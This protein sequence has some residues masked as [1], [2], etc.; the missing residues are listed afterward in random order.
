M[1]I[2]EADQQ[3]RADP[4][5]TL[6]VLRRLGVSVVRVYIAWEALAPD[7]SS[8]TSPAGFDAASPA[9]YPAASWVSYDATVRDAR[10]RG[11]HLLLDVGGP[12][13]QWATG[14]GAPHGGV[15][16][17]WK[18]SAAGFGQFVHA[19]ATRYSGHY[20][21]AGGSSPLP[22]I[23]F[24][25]IWNEPNLGIDLAPEAIENSAVETS[26]AMYRGLLDAGW[27]ALHQTGHSG[28]TILI[29]ELAPYGDTFGHNVP[30][31]FG[32]M[33]PLRFVRALYCVDSS[34]HPLAGP[35]AAARGCPTTT[36]ASKRFTSDHPALFQAGGYAV[37]P[38]PSGQVAPNVVIPD[39]PDFA[40]LAAL[41]KLEQLLDS[42]TSTYG[43]S[44]RFP[45]Y[46][47]EYGYFTDPPLSGTAPPALAAA[48]L[49]WAEYISWRNPR[50]RSWDQ[51]LL[52]DPPSPGPSKFVTG[53][54]FANGVQK[55][56]YAAY[57]MPI[58]LPATRASSGHELEVWGCVRPA[59]YARLDTGAPQRVQIQL[60]PRAG[61][62]FKTVRT[63]TI[64]D[65]NGYFET[66]VRFASSG[67]VRLAWSYP[68]GPTIYSRP[69]PITVS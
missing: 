34:L 35:A 1:S 17:V 29:G 27:S 20:I 14:A 52:I 46:S 63:V 26:P 15:V 54:E 9:A 37:H 21:P 56:S 13:P 66:H 39:E 38:Y 10:A 47:T 32:Y 59:R 40:N 4:S 49:N 22:R 18:P 53:L 30:G 36:A 41:P 51:F 67:T 65:P 57:R 58:Y 19:V 68:R 6:D 12:A 28:D 7:A 42:V 25:S 2:F 5:A 8:S 43:A 48:Y 3:L 55:P 62:A 33:V 60:R 44:K 50:I 16:G 24:W 31:N 11:M 45:L 61:S 64:T 69:V 23:N